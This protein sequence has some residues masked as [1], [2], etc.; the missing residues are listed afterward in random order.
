MSSYDLSVFMPSIRTHKQPEWYESLL[1]SCTRFSFEIVIA[2]PFDLHE[3]LADLPNVQFIRTYSHPTKASQLALLVC[4]GDL[5][6][7]TTDD[8]LFY[9]GAIDEAID[10]F[11][12]E[13]DDGNGI[14]SMRYIEGID[15]SNKTSYG[16]SYWSMQEWLI[17]NGFP[18]QVPADWKCNAQ[19][20]MP[21]AKLLDVGGF[22]CRFEYLVHPTA[23]MELRLQMM[24]ARMIDSPSDVSNADHYPWYSVDHGPIHDAQNHGDL[25]LFVSLWK[26]RCVQQQHVDPSTG[27][28]EVRVVVDPGRVDLFNHIGY[29]DHWVRRF[30]AVESCASSY[31]QL[32]LKPLEVR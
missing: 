16:A 31:D 7:H 32:D 29:P 24:G 19:F 22:D 5:V 23:D 12:W 11:R 3:K 6:Y 18:I 30:G 1:R 15:H 2:G 10:F 17:G 20:M 14:M 27:K 8:V 9:D 13:C 26:S 21:R 25:P 28:Q 4:K